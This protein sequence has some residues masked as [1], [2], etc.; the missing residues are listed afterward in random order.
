MRTCSRAALLALALGLGFASAAFAQRKPTIAIMPAQYF[1]ADPGSAQNLTKGLVEE[2]GGQGY[3]VIP[4]DSASVTF[5]SMGLPPSRNLA[6]RTAVRFGRV[7]RADLVAYPRLLSVGT[8]AA[9]PGTQPG[10]V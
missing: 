4:M 8:P 6:D 7:L 9:Q 5:A 2:F 10:A 3:R 1:Q